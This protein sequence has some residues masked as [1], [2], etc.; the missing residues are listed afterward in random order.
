[1]N[2]EEFFL[3]FYPVINKSVGERLILGVLINLLF[4]GILLTFNIPNRE[5]I[6][7]LSILLF[8]SLFLRKTFF[9]F[10]KIKKLY[11]LPNKNLFL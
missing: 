7:I 6:I 9:F 5:F 3:F 10:K 1:M 8:L 4:G 2:Y 11:Y